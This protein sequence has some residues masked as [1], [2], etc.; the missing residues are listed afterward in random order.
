MVFRTRAIVD[1]DKRI[2]QDT[3]DC[4]LY[5]KEYRQKLIELNKQFDSHEEIRFTHSVET[6]K[7]P[8]E[9]AIS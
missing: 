3:I 5:C 9:K 6:F 2:V 1:E 4:L 7:F 8:I